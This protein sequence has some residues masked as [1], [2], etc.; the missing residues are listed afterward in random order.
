MQWQHLSMGRHA[1]CPVHETT[2]S[3]GSVPCPAQTLD[4]SINQASRE[5]TDT[6]SPLT[7]SAAS[8]RK[9]CFHVCHFSLA[10][11]TIWL[12]RQGKAAAGNLHIE[13]GSMSIYLWWAAAGKLDFAFVAVLQPSHALQS[14][15]WWSAWCS[16][17]QLIRQQADETPALAQTG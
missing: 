14:S 12:Q 3:G 15:T 7:T 9:P 16:T 2:Q 5:V 10:M 1:S 6:A 17:Y 8:R 11:H 13:T 4:Q